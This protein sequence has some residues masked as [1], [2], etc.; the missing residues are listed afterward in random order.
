MIRRPPRSTL[1]SS[2]AAS[3]VYKRQAPY[4]TE[5]SQGSQRSLSGLLSSN[6]M[7]DRSRTFQI[8]T[9]ILT[10][11]E[12]ALRPTQ[13]DRSHSFKLN[14]PAVHFFSSSINLLASHPHRANPKYRPAGYGR[15]L[16]FRARLH[17]T[18]S[19]LLPTL[20]AL[21]RSTPCQLPTPI[22]SQRQVLIT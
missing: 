10:P 9:I 22:P 7:M 12:Y 4:S 6:R 1:S 13:T 20:G 11:A 15:S 14:N 21:N 8:G 3:D 18:F 17:V 2:S 19:S 5:D 16:Q